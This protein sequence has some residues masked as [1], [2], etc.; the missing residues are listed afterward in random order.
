M[1]YAASEP[2]NQTFKMAGT[3]RL[4][5]SMARALPSKSTSTTGL[6]VAISAL[7]RSFCTSG[8]VISER[9]EHSPD[10]SADSPRAATT[11][12]ALRAVATA[13][14]IISL[15]LRESLTRV[16]P[17]SV[18]FLS[19]RSSLVRLEPFAY[20]ILTLPPATFFI[21]S[22]RLE[23]LS[24]VAAPHHVPGIFLAA[25]ASGPMRA[26]VPFLSSGSRLSSFLSS[27]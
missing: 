15:S 3:L 4:S 12:S 8:I 21:P 2:P 16:L 18:E 11:T 25:S 14:A 1:E 22:S 17:N 26:I 19:S 20:R 7:S 13:S 23:Y 6:P 27:T 5:Q 10:I 24:S 9:Q